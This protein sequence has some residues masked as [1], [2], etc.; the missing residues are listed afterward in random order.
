MLTKGK[1]EAPVTADISTPCRWLGKVIR[2]DLH[3]S[4]R[5]NTQV[6]DCARFEY[7]GYPLL[8]ACYLRY[9]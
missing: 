2:H 9:L 7:C 3:L 8:L 4:E 1:T 5:A 6:L